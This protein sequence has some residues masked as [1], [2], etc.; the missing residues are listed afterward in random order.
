MRFNLRL[1]RFD[2]WRIGLGTGLFFRR[3]ALPLG[4]RLL[5]CILEKSKRKSDS[6]MIQL[7]Q[8]QR[9]GQRKQNG[10]KGDETRQTIKNNDANWKKKNLKKFRHEIDCL[11]GGRLTT[12]PSKKVSRSSVK[13]ERIFIFCQQIKRRKT[14][15][16]DFCD[17]MLVRWKT[18]QFLF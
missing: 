14:S 18:K 2:F 16:Y 7:I 4:C 3:R 9:D 8:H 5:I 10:T 13:W 15:F 11:L 17:R 1:R 6:R 12:N